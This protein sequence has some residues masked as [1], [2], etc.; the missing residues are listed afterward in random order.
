MRARSAPSACHRPALLALVF[1]LCGVVPVSAQDEPLI[2]RPGP[3][4]V[5][6]FETDADKDGEPDG[7]YNLRD[8]KLAGGGVVGPTCLRFENTRRG[9]P[10]RASRAFGVEGKETEAI[11]IG[12]WIRAQN[13]VTGERIGEDP[14][15]MI[16]FLG[17]QIRMTAR[18]AIGPWNKIAGQGWVRVAKRIPV[19]PGTHDAIMSLGLLGATGVLEV[20]GMTFDLIPVGGKLTSNLVLNGD[21]ELGTPEPTQWAVESGAHRSF[22]GHESTA[23][24]ELSGAGAKAL[25]GL[26][27]PVEQFDSLN[28]RMM[29]R[30]SNLRGGGGAAAE[31]FFLDNDGRP[32]FGDD[33]GIRVFSWGGAFDWKLAQR[34][35][36]VPRSAVR[37]VLQIEKT[38]PRG[39]LRVDDIQVTA[40]P[41]PEAGS[42]RPY[43]VQD[44]TDT[45]AAFESSARIEPGSALDASGLLTSGAASHGRVIVK[46]GRFHFE[47]GGRARFFGALLL[48]PLAYQDAK[49]AESLADRLA[50]SGINLVHLGT[51]DIPFGPA[52]SL[53]DDTRDDTKALDPAALARLDHLIAN[54]KSRGIYI[55]LELMSGRRFRD[56][57]ALKDA[58]R[59]PPGGGPAAAFDPD[60]RTL[61]VEAAEALLS[62]MNP[63]TG[64]ALRDDPVLAYVTLSGELSLFDLTEDPNALPPAEAEELK[65][66]AQKVNMGSGRRF[67]QATEAATWKAEA[68]AL[69]KFGLKCPIAGVSHW[70]REPEFCATQ[71]ASG[72]DFIDDR[73]Y[74][75]PPTWAD[76]LHRSM[77]WDPGAALTIPASKKRKNDRPFAIGQWCAHTDG[78]WALPYEAADLLF[79]AR[80]AANEDW[81]AIVRRGIYLQPKIWGAASP[82]TAGGEDRFIAPETIN[83]N[84]AVFALLPHA[85]SILMRGHSDV[86]TRRGESAARGRL[87]IDT[88]HTQALAG[89]ASGKAAVFDTTAISTDNTYAVIAVSSLG[90]EPIARSQR[91]LV[92]AIGRVLP[93]GFAWNDSWRRGV[94]DP[95]RPP[96]LLEP[97]QGKV[98]WKHSGVVRA[99]ELDSSGK[100]RGEAK[101]TK[102]SDSVTL[103]IDTSKGTIHWELV[104]E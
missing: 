28:V 17:D 104:V 13:I 78:A 57:D 25:V 34:T 75:S 39:A 45:W 71:A 85:A 91:L 92:T 69:R 42:W 55:A 54:L 22:P 23:A 82:G 48:P 87:A 47:K 38:D 86:S 21:F 14:A 53:F 68:S 8:A 15:L 9:R 66:L 64:L 98:V 102:A 58:S 27:L 72:L 43:H 24:L 65:S 99:F 5:E 46:D 35:F 60:V 93:T 6:D 94:A 4:A 11:V 89:W 2:E 80:T 12:L 33:Q 7:W 50:R 81:D 40:S 1:V 101:L 18:G 97:V 83:G 76:P 103:A 79:T 100:R 32:L 41:N 88:P 63:E 77:V 26:S 67:W 74:W 61:A 62:H 31:V 49:R 96:L 29:V 84:P 37:A 59:L 3:P 36:S 20:D 56:G 10:A 19:P 51:L 30:A 73:L 70:R 16:D 90:K 52:Q 95:G 44:D